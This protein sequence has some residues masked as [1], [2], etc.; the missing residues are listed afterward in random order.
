[1]CERWRRSNRRRRTK[2][3]RWSS[4]TGVLSL[5]SP[6]SKWI[7]RLPSTRIRPNRS[8]IS[9]WD[10]SDPRRS[11]ASPITSSWKSTSSRASPDCG[12][13]RFPPSRTSKP[14]P[15]MT[16][17]R[18][19]IAAGA[20]PAA[21]V[22]PDIRSPDAGSSGAPIPT[23]LVEDAELQTHPVPDL[24]LG[25]VP[26]VVTFLDGIARW[27]VMAYDG[28]APLVRAYVAA[29]ARRRPTRGALRTTHEK[30]RDFAVAPLDRM[31]ATHR[32]LLTKACSDV[33]PASG[34]H[35]GHP[36]LYLETVETA[37]RRARAHVEREIAEA[38]LATL[39]DDEWLV[40]DGLLSRSAA[41]AK[42]PR[43]MGLIR[44]H[45][46]QFLEGRGLELALTLPAGHRTSV[47]RVQGGHTRSE[48]Y[49]WY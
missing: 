16:W 1:M 41:V 32:A 10:G 8:F 3:A 18:T 44:S 33:E 17:W 31:S 25:A 13:W 19:L 45:G 43:A 2:T 47:F 11:C 37:V 49:S 46:T 20:V 6:P 27:S 34:D 40:L 48:V 9:A 29:A 23:D 38:T 24:G 15:S 22:P 5:G 26:R 39:A 12:S 35:V 7:R 36:L 42:H 28:Y 21:F 30:S 14:P 4:R